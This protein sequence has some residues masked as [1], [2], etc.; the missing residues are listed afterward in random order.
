MLQ[1]LADIVATTLLIT[2]VWILAVIPLRVHLLWKFVF[3][4]VFPA[5]FMLAIGLK[6]F[7]V[8]AWIKTLSCH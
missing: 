7:G 3:W 5:S 6:Y 4:M 2:G 8:I 1:F